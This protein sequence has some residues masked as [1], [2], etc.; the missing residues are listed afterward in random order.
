MAVRVG[1]NHF[2]YV[3]GVRKYIW[4]V[5]CNEENTRNGNGYIMV[6]CRDLYKLVLA[7]DFVDYFY[8]SSSRYF[9]I[10]GCLI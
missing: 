8:Y 10:F 7:F 2:F 6:I 9:D 1:W 5:N 3:Y 4:F